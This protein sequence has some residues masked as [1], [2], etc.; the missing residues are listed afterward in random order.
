MRWSIDT[1]VWIDAMAG[2][3]RAENA[4]KAA[5]HDE[6]CGYSSI[7]RLEVL[8]FSRLTEGEMA[9]FRAMLDQYVEVPIDH[10]VIEEA[11]RLR[12]LVKV[13]APDAIVAATALIRHATLITRNV[14][15]FRRIPGLS[16][17]SPDGF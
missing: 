7:S 15:D 12:R 3:L 1:N 8:S 4:L 5:T 13:K 6:S 17:R 14:D 11:A 10:E 2:E 9:A 16:S